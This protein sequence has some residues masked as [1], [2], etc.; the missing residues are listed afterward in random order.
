VE[1]L[2]V[3]TIIGILIAL[4]LPAVQAAREAARRMQCLNNLKQIGLATHQAAAAK[5]LLPPLGTSSFNNAMENGPYSKVVGATIFFWLLP[6]IEQQALYDQGIADRNPSLP[7]PLNTYGTVRSS[8]TGSSPNWVATGICTRP[9]RIYLCP[10][11]PTGAYSRGMVVSTYGGAHLYGA[12]CY[13]ANYLVFG[14]PYVTG[15]DAAHMQGEGSFDGT[16]RDGTSSTIMFAERYASCGSV[17]GGS[18]SSD[19][20]YA[21]IWADSSTYFRPAF[22]TTAMDSALRGADPPP[23]DPPPPVSPS[24]GRNW[25][26]LT[27]QNNP[28]WIQSCD[29][30]RTQSGHPGLINVCF[31]DGSVR[32]VNTSIDATVWS[33]LCNPRDGNAIATDW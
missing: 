18:A 12:C 33:C 11:D 17:P 31:G 14:A 7:S 3:I 16:F 13:P 9:V 5:G 20:V 24:F 8:L 6:H 1:L 29:I 4:L 22:C 2:V 32:A 26:C 30:R 23:P 27:P 10:D 15:S 28:D 25:T 19:Y 21:T